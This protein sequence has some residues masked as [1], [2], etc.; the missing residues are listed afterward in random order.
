MTLYGLIGRPLGHSRSAEYFNAKFARGNIDAEYRL[1]ELADIRE[2]ESLPADI[3]GFNVTIPFKQSVMALLDDISP[4][5]AAVGAV[6]CVLCRDG[7]RTGYNTDVEG[8]RRSLDT[9]LGDNRVKRALVFGVGGASKAVQY[10]LRER[11]ID[12]ITVSRDTSRAD[13]RYDDVTADTVR[14]CG[15]VVNATPVGMY[16]HTDEAP[17][18]PYGALGENHFLFDA[19]YN[20]PQ[21]MFLERGLNAGAR[22]LGGETMFVAQAEASW[23]IWN[24]NQR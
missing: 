15:L 20:P 9:L 8:V 24:G 12:C 21:T 10:V 16:P 23:R 5:A 13:M 11:D 19:V 2:A 22:I 17:R 3:A 18:I 7:R 14:G 4:E 6:N 1:F